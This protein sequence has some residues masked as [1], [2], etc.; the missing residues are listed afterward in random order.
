ML[1][2]HVLAQKR[3]ALRLPGPDPRQR[4]APWQ[5]HLFQADQL[6][7]L[8]CKL[9]VLSLMLLPKRC[10]FMHHRQRADPNVKRN[11][12]PTAGGPSDDDLPGG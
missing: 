4:Y 11:Y 10:L 9:I 12:I 3:S 7:T 1:L 8:R 2:N 5:T 6:H